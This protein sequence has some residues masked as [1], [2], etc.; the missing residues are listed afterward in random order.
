MRLYQWHID[1]SKPLTAKETRL[2]L[3][4]TVRFVDDVPGGTLLQCPCGKEFV[5]PPVTQP[6]LENCPHCGGDIVFPRCDW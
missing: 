5:D 3:A 1:Y 4:D 2:H 6:D